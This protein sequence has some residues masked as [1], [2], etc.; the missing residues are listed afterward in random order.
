[1]YLLPAEQNYNTYRRELAVIVKFI[2][3]YSYMLNA[4]YQSTVHMDHN[5]LIEFFNIEYHEDIFARWANKLRLLNIRIQHI[6]GKKN[7]VADGLSRVIFN[8]PD[9]FPDRLVG[10]LAK[11]VFLHRDDNEWFWK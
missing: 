1:M 5:P 2:K 3:K 4:K 6:P 11:E 9:C 8:N 10:K 7:M